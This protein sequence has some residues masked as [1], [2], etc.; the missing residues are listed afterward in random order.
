[1]KK[2][3]KRRYS[4]GSRLKMEQRAEEIAAKNKTLIDEGYTFAGTVVAP[5][6]RGKS[7]G[8]YRP[9]R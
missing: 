3:Y 9:T 6:R 4:K 1:M 8:S 5:Y 7:P 2:T